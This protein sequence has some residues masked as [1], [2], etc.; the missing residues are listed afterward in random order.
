MSNILDHAKRELELAGNDDDFNKAILN[1]IEA[2]LAYGHSG[3]SAEVGI[4]ILSDLLRFRNLTPLTDDPAEWMEVTDGMWQSCRNA[5]AF[6]KDGGQTYYLLSEGEGKSHQPSH[7]SIHRITN[8]PNEW[9]ASGPNSHQNIFDED[10]FSNDH[11]VTYYR[12]SEGATFDSP[13]PSHKSKSVKE[14]AS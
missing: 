6:S 3:T 8:D 5:E 4:E 7:D 11:G 2:F 13:T 10:V 9:S 12:V 1:S 14:T